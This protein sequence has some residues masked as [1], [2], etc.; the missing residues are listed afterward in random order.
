MLVGC[1]IDVFTV[2]SLRS[3]SMIFSI[4]CRK[5]DVR[6]IGL[7]DFALSYH[8]LPGFGRKMTL[9][10]FHS[11][12]TYPCARHALS[13][14]WILSLMMSNNF[15]NIIGHILSVPGDL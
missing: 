9:L 1:I 11:F 10:F 12:G 7:Y 13:I 3:R 8:F 14:L 6:L 15:Y 4:V 5:N 2:V